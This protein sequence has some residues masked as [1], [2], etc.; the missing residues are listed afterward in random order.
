VDINITYIE[1]S[2]CSVATSEM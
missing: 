1:S 2:A